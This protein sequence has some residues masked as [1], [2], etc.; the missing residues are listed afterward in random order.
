MSFTL[1]DK[2]GNG[3]GSPL[4]PAI[5]DDSPASQGV[6]DDSPESPDKITNIE[7]VDEDELGVSRYQTLRKSTISTSERKNSQ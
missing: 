6:R 1:V 2:P 5:K 3:S 4:S 7:T